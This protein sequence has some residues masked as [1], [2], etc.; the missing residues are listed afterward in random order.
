MALQIETLTLG[1]L[2]T[3]AFFLTDDTRPEEAVLVDA[4]PGA[5]QALRERLDGRRLTHLLLTHGHFDHVEDAEEVRR[6]TKA[7]ACG[8]RA[9]AEF[10]ENPGLLAAALLPGIEIDPVNIDQWVEAGEKLH[11]LGHE[12]DVRLV[13]GHA[14]GNLL[15]HF[16][17]EKVAFVGDAIF[18]GGV[19]R[20]DIPGGDWP[21]LERSIR[22]QIYTLPEA[23]VLY[24]GHGP[25]TT[26]GEEKRTNPFVQ[27]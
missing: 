6:E 23:T 24:P 27:G 8:H 13:P 19:G 9:D 26:V 14:P 17:Q 1:M 11:V 2:A 21:T 18:N 12:V 5:M 10:F 7:P 15:F 22:E 20:F 25:E 4:P 16:P 3:N